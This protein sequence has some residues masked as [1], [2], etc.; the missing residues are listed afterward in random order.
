MTKYTARKVIR[1]PDPKKKG[2]IVTIIP[3][4]VVEL[5]GDLEEQ[6]LRKGSVWSNEQEAKAAEAARLAAKGA[7]EI[8]PALQGGPATDGET[9]NDETLGATGAT[10]ADRVQRTD[11]HATGAT[12]APKAKAKA[13]DYI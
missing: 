9:G 3:G 13:Q 10:G 5:T 11:T 6:A 12:G 2:Q 7:T 8:D 4:Q 1:M